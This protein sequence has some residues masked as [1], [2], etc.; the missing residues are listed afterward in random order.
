M[1]KLRK[2]MEAR[3]KE[4]KVKTSRKERGRTRRTVNI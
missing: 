1:K 3:R 2:K 4:E